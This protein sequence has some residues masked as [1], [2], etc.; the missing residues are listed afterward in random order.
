MTMPYFQYQ[1]NTAP[2]WQDILL[3][4]LGELPF[5]VFEETEDGLLAYVP[6]ELAGEQLDADIN[7][8]QS[9]FELSWSKELLPDQNWNEV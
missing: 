4:F 2:E 6:A 9:R 3:A 5:E 1:F 7:D 8:L